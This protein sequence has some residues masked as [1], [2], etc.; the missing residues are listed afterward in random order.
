LSVWGILESKLQEELRKREQDLQ[1]RQQ[2][3][4]RRQNQTGGG[5]RSQNPHNWPPLPGTYV[6]AA[7]LLKVIIAGFIPVEPCFYQA[8]CSFY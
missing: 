7:N 4:E 3:F 6:L 2:E 8:S 5:S 1:R